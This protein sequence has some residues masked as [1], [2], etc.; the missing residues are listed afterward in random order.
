MTNG[1]KEEKE[2]KEPIWQIRVQRM[3]DK[4]VEQVLLKDTHSTKSE[5]I[6]Q[7]VREKLEKMGFMINKEEIE[8][9]EELEKVESTEK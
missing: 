1:E 5:F 8:K 7:A 6:R 3:L 4:M 9:L 2:E